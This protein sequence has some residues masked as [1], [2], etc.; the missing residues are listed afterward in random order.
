MILWNLSSVAP[1][2]LLV[3]G[4]SFHDILEVLVTV[5]YSNLFYDSQ[6]PYEKKYRSLGY[7]YGLLKLRSVTAS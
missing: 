6:S 4:I 3:R 7:E 2:G 1:G 5:F